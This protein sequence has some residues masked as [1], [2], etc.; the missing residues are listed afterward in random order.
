M[1]L[2][3]A[4]TRGLLILKTYTL[5]SLNIRKAKLGPKFATKLKRHQSTSTKKSRLWH[6]PIKNGVQFNFYTMLLLKL[7]FKLKL[8][9]L[10]TTRYDFHKWKRPFLLIRPFE[11]RKGSLK[12]GFYFKTA[13]KVKYSVERQ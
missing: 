7:W 4:G 3:S 9:S 5:Q 8:I 12:F 13:Y 10:P 6:P 1:P 2:Y 11:L